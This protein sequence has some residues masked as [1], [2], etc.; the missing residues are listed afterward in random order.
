[1]H[2]NREY[3]SNFIFLRIN[4]FSKDNSNVT[5]NK[6]KKMKLLTHN[7]LTSKIL[8]NVV[9]GY[10]LKISATKVETKEVDFQPEFVNRMMRKVDYNALYQAAQQVNSIDINLKL[11]L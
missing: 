9:T 10:P 8:K 2:K 11:R 5:K 3:N 6:N 7:M 4:L 1:M